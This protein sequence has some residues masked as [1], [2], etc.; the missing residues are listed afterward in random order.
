MTGDTLSLAISVEAGAAARLD[1]VL[2]YR[3]GPRPC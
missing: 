2:A 3:Y 1:E